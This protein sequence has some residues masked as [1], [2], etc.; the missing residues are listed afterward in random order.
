MVENITTEQSLIECVVRS[1]RGIF[2]IVKAG[3]D[4]IKDDEGS[5]HATPD[6]RLQAERPRESYGLT[7]SNRGN[8]WTVMPS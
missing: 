4:L 7:Q 1:W 3:A 8:L 5:E 6:A 2:S